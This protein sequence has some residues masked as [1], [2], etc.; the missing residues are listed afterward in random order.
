MRHS[1]KCRILLVD[2][3]DSFTYNVFD[4][5]SRLGADVKVCFRSEVMDSSE[6]FEYDGLVISPGPGNPESMPDLTKILEMA[7]GKMPVLG[8]CLG[9][10]AIANFYG[11]HI[12]KAR[13]MHGKISLVDA[14]QDSVLLSGIPSVFR[15]VRY[16]SLVVSDLPSELLPLLVSREDNCLMAFTHRNLPVMGIQFHPEAHL[17]EYG[18]PLLKN[19]LDVCYKNKGFFSPET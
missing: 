3:F 7:L 11:A 1:H 14:L 16:H 9:H 18:L 12:I 10:Q 2:N 19:W 6:L 15:V 13:P 8:I 4:Y 5:L 17:T